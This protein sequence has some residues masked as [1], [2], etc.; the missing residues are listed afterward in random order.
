MVRSNSLS[1]IGGDGITVRDTEGALIEYNIAKDCR[2]QN[3]GYNAGIWPFQA[4][5][6]VVQ[7]NEVYRTHGVQDGQGFDC[8][9]LSMYTVMQY[10]YSHDNEGGFMLIMNGFPHTAPTIRYNISQN[11]KDKTFEFA[12]GTPAGTMI[13]NNTI[14]SDSVLTGRGGVFDMANTR[15]G[16]GNREVFAFN[17]IFYYPEGQAF[18]CGEINNI[19]EKIN[20]Y[21]NAYYGGITPPEEEIK[22]IIEDPK[23]VRV[24]SGPSENTTDIPV[25]GEHLKGELDGYLL[26][27]DSPLIEAGVTIEDVLEEYSGI[28]TDRRSLSPVEIHEQAKLGDSIDFVADKYLPEITGVKYKTDFFGTELPGEGQK[29]SIG[30]A[31]FTLEEPKSEEPEEPK[32]EELEEPKS[33]EPKE[34]KSE[35][36]EAP[37][38]EKPEESKPKEPKLEELEQTE[39][40]KSGSRESDVS[41]E[42]DVVSP[43]TG[44]YMPIKLLC[45]LIL[46]CAIVLVSMSVSKLKKQR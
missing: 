40:K 8:D 21:N 15:A 36:P 26:Q 27:E 35:E 32:S 18:Y 20:L 43:A 10:N 13:Y 11:D 41:I 39:D 45:V 33:E 37:K 17:N 29:P 44:D 6:T 9:H 23:L 31:E 42:K 3:T 38:P 24:G 16:T 4:S 2:Y 46:L 28:Q 34:P 1:Q 12:R 5:N 19:K 25:T 22:A 14:Y 7:Y 30:A